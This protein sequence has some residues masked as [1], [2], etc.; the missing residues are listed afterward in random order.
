MIA[1]RSIL[2]LIMLLGTVLAVSACA[3]LPTTEPPAM[4]VIDVRIEE[5]AV[6]EQK[7]K[8]KVRVQNPNGHDL[9]VTGIKYELDLNGEPFLRGVSGLEFTV[10]RYGEAVTEV[11][12]ISTLFSFIRQIE[13][14]QAGAVKELRYRLHGKLSIRDRIFRLPFDYTGRLTLPSNKPGDKTI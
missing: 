2:N 3:N 9:V 8:I 11:S 7:Y 13:A 1:S 4:S 5:A 6:L 10:S 12:G 14:L